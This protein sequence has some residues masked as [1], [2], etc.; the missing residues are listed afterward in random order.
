[1]LI[2]NRLMSLNNIELPVSVIAGLYAGTLTGTAE[3]SLQTKQ[4]EPA[5]ENSKVIEEK[6]SLKSLGNNRKNILIII[7]CPDAVFLPDDELNFLTG[8]LGA[9]RLSLDDVAIINIYHY[10]DVSYRDFIDLFK[11]KVVLLFE[12]DPVSFGLPV[13]FPYYQLQAFAGNTFLYSP[14]L[15]RL[16]N[17]KLE[18]SKLWVCLKRLFNL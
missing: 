17:D 15:K 13:N 10:P 18:K 2:V 11:S 6:S 12:K 4:T 1:M 7:Y 3:N 14:S 9:C 16:E 5:A 8:I